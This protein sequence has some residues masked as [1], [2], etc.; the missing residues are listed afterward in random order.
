MKQLYEYLKEGFFND[1]I[2]FLKPVKEI[3]NMHSCDF[4]K[5]V[6]VLAVLVFSCTSNKDAKNKYASTQKYDIRISSGQNSKYKYATVVESNLT[7]SINDQESEMAT[8]I[9]NSII[10]D[11]VVDS[12]GTIHTKS[13]YEEFKLFAK[14][15]EAER[16][17]D[18]AT[19]SL[20]IIP[21]DK[22][23]SAFNGAV[24]ESAM[25]L[26]GTI[27][28]VKG[29]DE[30]RQKMKKLAGN[31]AESQTMVNNAFNQYASETF[32]KNSLKQSFM[33]L[34]K[35]PVKIGDSWSEQ[36][37]VSAE[38]PISYAIT[39]TLEDV[40]DNIAFIEVNAS[41]EADKQP[42][43]A[44]NRSVKVTLK[45]NQEG[46][47]KIDLST[48]MMLNSNSILKVS[49]ENEIIGTIV[50]FRMETRT[51]IRGEKL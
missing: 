22:I 25:T 3:L 31:N 27:H 42:I 10:H 40:E 48:G 18:A 13:T 8:R 44:N 26:D 16:E 49:G 23:F 30:L 11:L 29:I 15:N 41:F 21:S 32:V 51:S 14:Q 20:S 46:T 34:P 35:T 50:P 24:F 37:E 4:L 33:M 12:S 28:S 38:I 1:V 6:L 45:G 7:H 43:I 47:I 39:Y 9:Q 2:L 19:A 36:S 5:T 17:I